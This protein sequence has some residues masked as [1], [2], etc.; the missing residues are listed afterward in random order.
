M[1][2]AAFFF[3][4]VG[5]GQDG[6]HINGAVVICVYDFLLG[7]SGQVSRPP[8]SPE[9][10]GDAVKGIV[11]CKEVDAPVLVRIDAEQEKYSRA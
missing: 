6:I 3:Q 4:A 7:S 1:F 2:G 8:V 9:I 10:I 11:L 5:D